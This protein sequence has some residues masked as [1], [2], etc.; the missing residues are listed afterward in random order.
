MGDFQRT[1][2]DTIGISNKVTGVTRRPRSSGS[3]AFR[4]ALWS[5]AHA[6]YGQD[7]PPFPIIQTFLRPSSDCIR[8]DD[9]SEFAREVER[10]NSQDAD[11]PQ[12]ISSSG[13]F[14]TIEREECAST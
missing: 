2:S 5:H 9:A 10:P 8:Y 1:Q 13:A 6:G 14:C 7:A 4:E 11:Y 3:I 12:A